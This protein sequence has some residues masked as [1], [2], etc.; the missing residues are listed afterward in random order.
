[1]TTCT[2]L[3]IAETVSKSCPGNSEM[4]KLQPGF[5]P[6]SLDVICKRGKTAYN[7]NL[8]FREL[9]ETHLDK[10]ANASSKLEKSLVVSDVVETIRRGSPD[11]GFVREVDGVWCE[12]G[13]AIAREKCG[14]AFRDQL[15]HK[16][17]SSCENKK[18]R[19]QAKEQKKEQQPPKKEEKIAKRAAE[20]TT[21]EAP[22]KRQRVEPTTTVSA[23]L[24]PL[25]P[26]STKVLCAF[27]DLLK[28]IASRK[29]QLVNT[30]AVPL[31]FITVKAPTLPPP[32]RFPSAPRAAAVARG[33]SIESMLSFDLN[34]M[35]EVDEFDLGLA[36]F[37]SVSSAFSFSFSPAF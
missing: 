2:L 4:R 37:T 28:D 3:K 16:Y 31:P 8:H 32:A 21:E 36:R 35:P 34:E 26:K 14:G 33:C 30:E 15:S 23:P 29:E 5:K 27:G 18:K 1:M 6:S 25:S 7:H 17:K 9:I 22:K 24:P 11:G 10:Y 20:P 19:R 12:V 13:D